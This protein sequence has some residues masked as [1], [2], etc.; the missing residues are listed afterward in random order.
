MV[1]IGLT[2][3]IGMG[4]STAAAAFRRLGVPVYDADRAVH[5]LLARGGGA[6]ALIAAS[7]PAMVKD[8]AVDRQALGAIVFKDKLAL[9]NLERIVHPLVRKAQERFLRRQAARRKRLVV[10]DIPLLLEGDGG[11]RCDAVVVVSAPAFLQAQRVLSRRG[12]TPARFAGILR[13]QMPDREKRR[14]ATFVVE[15]GLGK[16]HSLRRIA[17]IVKVMRERRGRHWP[18][19]VRLRRRHA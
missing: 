18:P 12:M 11:R 10:L 13:Q 8:G 7:F 5:R 16:R 19:R 17:H 1:I 6:V 4:K 9:A 15:T 2:G 14:R 3:S